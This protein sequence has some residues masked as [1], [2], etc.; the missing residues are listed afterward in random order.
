MCRYL[1]LGFVETTYNLSVCSN[2]MALAVYGRMARLIIKHPSQ[3]PL[4]Q[5]HCTG[6]KNSMLVLVSGCLFLRLLPN[7]DPGHPV[8]AQPDANF[9]RTPATHL[10]LL[11]PPCLPSV[12]S[13]S[14]LSS[15]LARSPSAQRRARPP[16][17]HSLPAL[18]LSLRE[19]SRCRRVVLVRVHVRVLLV[20][21]FFFP[22]HV[23]YLMHSL[24]CISATQRTLR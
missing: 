16:A 19:H 10:Y 1:G 17:L 9:Q 2:T 15:P 12:P 3:Y 20:C 7:K 24:H 18:R 13:A 14:S 11:R 23:V 4:G 5:K 22:D 21:L 6:V 8:N